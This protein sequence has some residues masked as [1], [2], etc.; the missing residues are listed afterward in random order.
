VCS[1]LAVRFFFR[2]NPKD[3]ALKNAEIFVQKPLDF[4]FLKPG[5]FFLFL[6]KKTGAKNKNL[7]DFSGKNRDEEQ[8]IDS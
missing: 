8:I 2:D 7:A 1:L 3:L 4:L 5:Y 6:T